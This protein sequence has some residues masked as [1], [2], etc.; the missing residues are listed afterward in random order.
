MRI[1][2]VLLS[3]VLLG[4]ASVSEAQNC[5]GVSSFGAGPIRLDGG[6]TFGE[7]ATA[8]FG[9][10]SVG[11]P[12]GPF[13]S[14]AVIRTNFDEDLAGEDQSTTGFA[15]EGGWDV[16][17]S[18]GVRRTAA[19]PRVSLCPIAGFQRHTAEVSDGATSVD[20]T[21]RLLSAGLAL[22]AAFPASPAVSLVPFASLSYVKV[23]IKVEGSGIDVE[24]DDD[25]G[26]VDL[27]VGFVF[28][29]IFTVRP[30]LNIPVGDEEGETRFGVTAHI[31]FGSSRR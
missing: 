9:G 29:R 16:D 8:I 21:A 31:S 20:L 7:D 10:G 3:V 28:N 26:R 15:L 24:N 25:H 23:N 18:Q 19:A 1:T 11:A 13:A 2:P 14:L 22:G 12:R 4:V 6:V 5:L 27:G 30:L 17:L